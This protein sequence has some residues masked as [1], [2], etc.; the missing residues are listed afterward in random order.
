MVTEEA[1]EEEAEEAEVDLLLHLLI[2][3]Q[4]QLALQARVPRVRQERSKATQALKL[5]R[6]AT[7]AHTQPPLAARSA[8]S[9]GRAAMQLKL[10]LTCAVGAEQANTP[11]SLE[12][13]NALFVVPASTH[14]ARTILVAPTA[15][16]TLTKIKKA[17]LSVFLARKVLRQPTKALKQLLTACA[18]LGSSPLTVELTAL[19]AA[20]PAPKWSSRQ[21][22]AKVH[23]QLAKVIPTLVRPG[24]SAGAT[25]VRVTRLKKIFTSHIFSIIIR[26]IPKSGKA[27][28]YHG[29]TSSTSK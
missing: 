10:D 22:L 24:P 27:S 16:C 12:L 13:L 21:A 19:L 26:I 23:A 5:A 18:L 20:L 15:L 2:V 3:H 4:E 14:Q 11:H 29:I 17:R 7:R 28:C 6:I 9:A 25:M 1:E 8:P